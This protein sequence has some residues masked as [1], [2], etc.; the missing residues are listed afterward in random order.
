MRA[1]L[2]Y[3]C[4]ALKLVFTLRPIFDFCVREAGYEGVGRLRVSWWR[5]EAADKQLEVA[6]EAISEAARVR[7]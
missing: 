1:R 6:V 2:F 3:A 7:R 5:Q 4:L